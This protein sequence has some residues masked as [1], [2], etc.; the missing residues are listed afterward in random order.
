MVICWTEDM[1]SFAYG[2]YMI[3]GDSAPASAHAA[4]APWARLEAHAP[5]VLLITHIPEPFFSCAHLKTFHL[6]IH[7][8]GWARI[9]GLSDASRVL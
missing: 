2:H 1:Q 6:E 9:K 5:P 7:K 4:G 3:N 8:W